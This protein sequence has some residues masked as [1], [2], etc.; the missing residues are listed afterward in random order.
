[1]LALVMVLTMSVLPASAVSTFPDVQTHWGKSYIEAMTSANMFK[2]YEDGTF[3]PEN[4][5][6]TAEALA[7]C[8]RAVGLDSSTT[9]D[10]AT[11]RFDEVKRLLNNDQSWFYQEF[12]VCLATGILTTADLKTLYQSGAL[13]RPISK[14]DMAVYL[15]RA[16]QLGPMSERLTTYPM[17]FSDVSAIRESAKPSVYLLSI[18]GIVEG[19][20]KN[21]FG[22]KGEVTRAIMATMLTRSIAYMQ[23][24]GTS[25][26][27][28]AYTDYAF[29]QG[30]I[31]VTPNDTGSVILLNLN[32]DLTGAPIGA[33]SLPSDVTIYENNMES[34]STALKAG[35]HARVCY[36]NRGR[37]ASVRVSDALEVFTAAVSGIDGDNIA[38]TVEGEGR[39]V[40]MD[41]F[42]QVQIGA[43]TVGDRSIVDPAGGYTTAVCKL[44]DQG[45]LAAIQFT[46]GTRQMEGI[47]SGFTRATTTSASATIQVVGFDGVTRTFT[48]PSSATIT[49]NGMISPINSS[50]VG[51]YISLRISD[52]ENTVQS[53]A[54]DTVSEYVQGVVKSV[55]TSND[56]IT[57]SRL[58]N[59]K[60]TTYDVS[61]SAII[62][63]DGESTLL[64]NIKKNY[65]VTL[66]IVNDY[67][68]MVQASPSSAVT[69]GILTD[70]VFDAGTDT[71]VTFVV[72]QPDNTKISFKVDLA[73]PPTVVRDDVDS[74]VDKLR[75]G[76]E[77]EVTV[78][79]N[80]V[81]RIV[82]HTQSV[83][84]TGTIDRIIQEKT[85]YTLDMTLTSGE[86][87]SY[88]VNSTVSVM[89]NGKSVALSTL[90][91]GYRLGMA[92]N[93]DQVTSIEIQQAVNSGN[94]LSGSIIYVDYIEDVIY[95][96]AV[97]DTG[98][99]EM[100]TVAIT[101]S[102]IILDVATS[103][104]LAL[105]E[106]KSSDIVEVNGA[107]S[108]TVFKATII[109]RQ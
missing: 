62:T 4:K 43:K 25:P 29:Q 66:R 104:E 75:T 49:V 33:I 108:G 39:L 96:R 85:G 50:H 32:S 105:R 71:T 70:R 27:L 15:V 37:A 77:V 3:K 17:S 47:I 88:A 65:F 95:L 19:D 44:D 99:E 101:G 38:L 79:Y 5:L 12:S 56:T 92:V 68:T 7:L 40:T 102:T 82:A 86:E 23:S 34:T 35:R 13:T 24:H 18:Y 8:A 55:S 20:T 81:T 1:M 22:P 107:Y 14:E 51:H 57:L 9:L 52:E 11:D 106:L 91:P 90:K 53:A 26:D 30:T 54:V 103:E 28:P 87:V 80:E 89:Q 98:D 41:R 60:S 73:D 21:E 16:M 64:K 83:N 36:D 2:G 48:V 61:S 109:L 69:S 94:K 59:S 78:R 93:G 97:T 58:N 63:Y 67:V 100:V 31:A 84:V 45:R 76:D 72:T 46:G 74:T 10:I 6:T 42:T